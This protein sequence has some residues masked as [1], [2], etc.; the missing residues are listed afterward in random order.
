[1]ITVILITKIV[2]TYWATEKIL[3]DNL[4]KL[5]FEQKSRE[6]I[7]IES[8]ERKIKEIGNLLVLIELMGQILF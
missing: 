4:W 3:K 1:M 7:F 6:I 2:A 8:W 5:D